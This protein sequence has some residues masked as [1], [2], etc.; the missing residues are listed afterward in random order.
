MRV[1]MILKM[2][3]YYGDD[4]SP[5]QSSI[6]TAIDPLQPFPNTVPTHLTNRGQSPEQVDVLFSGDERVIYG[7][8]NAPL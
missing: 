2:L 1:P 6:L 8:S 5:L 7:P 3:L 4:T